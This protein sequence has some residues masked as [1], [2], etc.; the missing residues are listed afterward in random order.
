[1]T[2]AAAAIASHRGRRE[3]FY[4]QATSSL[5]GPKQCGCAVRRSGPP[6][7][8]LLRHP[9]FGRPHRVAS[10]MDPSAT[11]SIHPSIPIPL[12]IEFSKDES[13]CPSIHSIP[14]AVSFVGV[15]LHLGRARVSEEG[16]SS[17]VWE[18]IGGGGVSVGCP[19]W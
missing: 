18:E 2:G 4:E 8:S 19:T 6:S 10:P 13:L 17:F 1:M 14:L 3:M 9:Q 15:K 12:S 7:L 11:A 5:R 16:L